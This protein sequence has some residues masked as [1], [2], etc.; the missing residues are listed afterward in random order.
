MNI[1][2]I[3]KNK[4]LRLYID[5]G[6]DTPYVLEHKDSQTGVVRV[7]NTYRN[8]RQALSAYRHMSAFMGV[9]TK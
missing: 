8:Y 4:K 2:T 7:V 9:K 5:E 3:R 6:Y 1:K